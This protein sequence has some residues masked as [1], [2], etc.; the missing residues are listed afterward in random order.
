MNTSSLVSLQILYFIIIS[1]YKILSILNY[2]AFQQF[3]VFTPYFTIFTK[4]A[5]DFFNILDF[6]FTISLIQTPIA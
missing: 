4:Q 5:W 1:I 2:L 6:D 3:Y